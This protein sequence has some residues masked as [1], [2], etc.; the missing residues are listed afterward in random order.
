LRDFVPLDVQRYVNGMADSVG[1]LSSDILASVDE[2]DRL[3][4]TA[5]SE[6][7]QVDTQTH[8]AEQEN[9]LR[10]NASD[11]QLTTG[12]E[13]N[14]VKWI[15]LIHD[16]VKNFT[17]SVESTAVQRGAALRWP[18]LPTS[19]DLVNTTAIESVLNSTEGKVARSE[20]M[21]RS[22]LSE[23]VGN[24]I[25]ESALTTPLNT[26]RITDMG[27]ELHGRI[28]ALVQQSSRSSHHHDIS[29]AS[30]VRSLNNT[31]QAASIR[32]HHNILEASNEIKPAGK[33]FT[34]ETAEIP[35]YL[36]RDGQA[37]LDAIQSLVKQLMSGGNKT[38]NGL[39]EEEVKIN[40][41]LRELDKDTQAQHVA[42]ETVLQGIASDQQKLEIMKK[43]FSEASTKSDTLDNEILSLMEPLRSVPT[44]APGDEDLVQF[45]S[46]VSYVTDMINQALEHL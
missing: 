40:Q 28:E 17:S 39:G 20:G 45:N 11:S 19:S 13:L 23:L 6:L 35:P 38:E 33:S 5:R 12:D 36:L 25:S 26:T 46:T 31:V 27:N 4:D 41:T 21:F 42:T 14:G 15:P 24:N 10:M 16:S 43:Q 7:G 1:R 29:R 44:I 22:M 18:T 2:V 37:G 8:R 34:N 3:V 9:K 30:R 32:V